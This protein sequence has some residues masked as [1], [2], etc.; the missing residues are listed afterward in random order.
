MYML[1][2]F[3][4]EKKGMKLFFSF[5]GGTRDFDGKS[6][7]YRWLQKQCNSEHQHLQN[8][9]FQ[10]KV[11]FLISLLC[12]WIEEEKW[13]YKHDTKFEQ[14]QKRQTGG[15]LGLQIDRKWIFFFFFRKDKQ[16]LV[17]ICNSVTFGGLGKG[18]FNIRCCIHSTVTFKSFVCHLSHW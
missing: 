4:Y 10:M 17:E 8:C 16:V 5:N 18:W 12:S 1:F 9:L 11:F 7:L 3:R 6:D 13:P 15:K 2:I 14:K